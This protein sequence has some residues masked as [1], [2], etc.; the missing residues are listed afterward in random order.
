M[1]KVRH[2]ILTAGLSGMVGKK[3]VFRQM[4]DGRTIVCARPNFSNRILSEEQRTHHSR[5]Q[6]AAAYARTA[7]RINPLYAELSRGTAKNAYNIA[8]SD[9]FHPP[10]IHAIDRQEGY[11]C[12]QATDNVLV[13]RVL[14]TILDEEGNPLEQS[15][16]M[17]VDGSWWEY[18]TATTRKMRVEAWD[19]AGN[20]ARQDI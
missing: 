7:S 3:L 20:V 2:N 4:Q 6:Q 11:I 10:V 9:W 14:V 12:V 13:H 5:F 17:Q 16:A 8:L 1:A 19:L 15:Q 18:A